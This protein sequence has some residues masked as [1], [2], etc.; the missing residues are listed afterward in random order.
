VE[1]LVVGS[2]LIIAGRAR[3]N[4]LGSGSGWNLSDKGSNVILSSTKNCIATVSAGW[5]SVRGVTSHSTGK[6]FFEAQNTK[7]NALGNIGLAG[8]VDS[9]AALTD[10]FSSG[11][12]GN[13]KVF[14]FAGT[15][16]SSGTFS[17]SG[18]PGAQPIGYALLIALDFSGK[19]GWVYDQAAGAWQGGVSPISGGGSTFAWTGT[20]T[21]FCGASMNNANAI[22]TLNTGFAPWANASAAATCIGAGYSPWG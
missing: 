3:Q 1:D 4:R 19:K 5:Q 7:N 20:P 15:Q 22:V 12:S 13:T 11:G 6:F 2:A 10:F 16:L 9:T 21:L 18:F 14:T 8:V 17:G